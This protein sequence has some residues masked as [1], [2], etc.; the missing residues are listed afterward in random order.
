[1]RNRISSQN[2]LDLLLLQGQN[3]TGMPTFAWLDI[4]ETDKPLNPTSQEDM[5]IFNVAPSNVRDL[6]KIFSPPTFHLHPRIPK[7]AFLNPSLHQH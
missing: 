1:M 6:E 5:D 4:S 2:Q 3:S 7:L